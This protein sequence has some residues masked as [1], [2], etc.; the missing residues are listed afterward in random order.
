MFKR[1]GKFD[2]MKRDFDLIRFQVAN[3]QSIFLSDFEVSE[4]ECL[5]LASSWREGADGLDAAFL[6]FLLS[7][8]SF[9]FFLGF[10]DSSVVFFLFFGCH[11][12]S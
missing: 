12:C 6:S 9:F 3:G 10:M 7:F 4:S 8:L 2:L 1:L 11:F 5:A